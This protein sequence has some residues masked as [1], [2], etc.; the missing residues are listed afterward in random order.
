MAQK[1]N[2]ISLRLGLTQVWDSTLQN[3]GKLHN[4]YAVIFHNQLQIY[5]L[6]TQL[7]KLN[8][9]ALGTKQF[10]HSE[11]IVKLTIFYS[12]L[13]YY[14]NLDKII[15][16]KLLKLVSAWYGNRALIRIY[17]SLKWF[18]TTSLIF[19]YMWFLL[20]QN[21]PLNKTFWSLCRSLKMQINSKKILH[22]TC[23]PIVG[24]LQGFRIC[25]SGRFDNSR[26]QMAKTINYKLG[27]LPLIN[28]QSYVEFTNSE[29]HTK[30]GTCGVQL[31]LFYKINY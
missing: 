6:L 27:S 13:I 3:Y 28:L 1:I 17:L 15:S 10:N 4:N 22:S 23:G 11:N 18:S 14:P 5:K 12:N 29:I 19:N 7:F 8:N 30:L 20:K 31:W 16:V 24:E 25:L 26:N 2:P 9:F 21:T